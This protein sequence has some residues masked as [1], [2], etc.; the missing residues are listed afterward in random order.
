MSNQEDH[1]EKDLEVAL[2]SVKK[3]Q[4]NLR[5]ESCMQ[6]DKIFECTIRKAYVVAVYNSMSKGQSGGF[7]F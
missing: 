6:C 5:L 7:E 1:Y 3:C 2:Q 4:E